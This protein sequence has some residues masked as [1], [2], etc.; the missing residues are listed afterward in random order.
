MRV[1]ISS[2][3]GKHV[4]G[5]TGFLN[6]VTEARRVVGAVNQFLIAQGIWSTQFHDDTSTS[7]EE[8]LET[9]VTVHNNYDRD[10]DVSVHFNAYETTDKPMGTEVLFVTQDELAARMSAAISAAGEFPN[11]G[12]KYRD[13]LYFLNN[14]NEPAIL[15]EVCFVDS[16]ADADNYRQFFEAI[17]EAIGDVI[18]Q[19]EAVIV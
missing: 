12:G 14:T 13:N 4:A 16:E 15:I 5:A 2:G 17:C 11:R 19:S 18:A 10:L 1:V 8:N 6:E 9:I 3:H 7:Q